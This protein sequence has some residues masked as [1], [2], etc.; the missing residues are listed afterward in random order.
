MF[1]NTSIT[2]RIPICP[3]CD[4]TLQCDN[5]VL[6]CD[7]HGVFFRYGPHLIVRCAPELQAQPILT[8]LPWETLATQ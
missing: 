4:K 3:Q 6:C 8:L 1:N 7:E 2:P 5:D